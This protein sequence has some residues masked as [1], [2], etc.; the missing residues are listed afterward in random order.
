MPQ[1]GTNM[2]AVCASI[3][4][5]AALLIANSVAAEDSKVDLSKLTC[6][7]FTA[8]NNEN[9]GLVMMWFEGY[10]TDDE[11]QAIIDF[12]KMAGDLAQ[13]LIYCGNNPDADMVT[14]T[15]GIMGKDEDEG[16]GKDDSGDSGDSEN[17]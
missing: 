6:N 7:Q 1:K 5:A 2:K 14:A 12:Q 16:K 15:D 9:R 13:V 11:D 4:A 3:V 17:K 10:Y 8:Y